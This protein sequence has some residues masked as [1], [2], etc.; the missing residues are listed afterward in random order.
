MWTIFK[1]FI[2]FVTILLLFHVLFFGQEAWGILTTGS[3]REVPESE[4]KVLVAQ[5]CPTLCDHMDYSLPGPSVLGIL[6][7]RILEW[8]AIP[9]SGE[10]SSRP[11]DQTQEVPTALHFMKWLDDK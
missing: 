1:G 2:E 9:F 7:A 5:S 10:G 6:Q 3:A 8:V 4:V 11:R